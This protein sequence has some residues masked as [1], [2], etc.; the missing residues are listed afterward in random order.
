[1][2]AVPFV[3]WYIIYTLLQGSLCFFESWGWEAAP[4]LTLWVATHVPKQCFPRGKV[5]AF[6]YAANRAHSFWGSYLRFALGPWWRAAAAA[7]NHAPSCGPWPSSDSDFHTER[8]EISPTNLTDLSRSRR[9]GKGRWP[10]PRRGWSSATR[11]RLSARGRNPPRVGWPSARW[12]SIETRRTHGWPSSNIELNSARRGRVWK[13]WSTSSS[14][15][16]N[17]NINVVVTG[18]LLSLSGGG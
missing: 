15:T 12:S 17:V 5:W 4:P 16:C 13:W 3:S 18:L 14:N 1:M 7:R 10:S 9:R 8:S 2:H 6:A 11:R